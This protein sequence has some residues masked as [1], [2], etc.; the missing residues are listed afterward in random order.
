MAASKSSCSG[1]DTDL[2]PL[3]FTGEK[4]KLP[5]HLVAQDTGLSPLSR[6][7]GAGKDLVYA[8]GKVL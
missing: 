4:K 6:R 3:P 7:G 2:N 8:I 5:F 1:K